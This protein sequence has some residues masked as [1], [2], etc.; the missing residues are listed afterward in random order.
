MI[1]GFKIELLH[2]LDKEP[3]CTLYLQVKN[4]GTYIPTSQIAK[5]NDP[6]DINSYLKVVSKAKEEIF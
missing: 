6:H 4:Q 5:A 2:Y 1:K 3:V